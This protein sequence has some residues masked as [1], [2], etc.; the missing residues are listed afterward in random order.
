MRFGFVVLLIV[1]VFLSVFQVVCA[2]HAIPAKLCDALLRRRRHH[3][4]AALVRVLPVKDHRF[5][6]YG[7][8][9]RSIC[10][11]VNNFS[12]PALRSLPFASIYYTNLSSVSFYAWKASAYHR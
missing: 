5:T 3:Q 7:K 2:V 11:R 6:G 4:R 8:F 1:N 12:P 9:C 10:S